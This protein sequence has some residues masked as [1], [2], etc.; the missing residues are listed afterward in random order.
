MSYIFRLLPNLFLFDVSACASSKT[1]G[2]KYN[3]MINCWIIEAENQNGL[4]QT[5][6]T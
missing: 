4:S 1:L 2:V 5:G 6:Y 3:Y